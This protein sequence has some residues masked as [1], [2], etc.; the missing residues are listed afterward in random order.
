MNIIVF[1]PNL[2]YGG[3]SNYSIRCVEMLKKEY[4]NV[5][6]VTFY[7]NRMFESDDLYLI[8]GKKLINKIY[9]LR[10]LI[11][12]KGVN[13]VITSIDLAPL[14]TKIAC[15]GIKID[16]ISVFH[17]RP[18]LYKLNSDSKLKNKMFD[19][20][21]V[22]SFMISK[23]VITVSKGLEYEVKK[24]Y[25]K[26][27]NKI[28]TIY[29]PIIK[30]LEERNFHYIDIENKKEINILNIGW[31]SRLKNQ[32]EILEAIKLID[33][34]RFKLTIVGGIK[35]VDYYKKI[36]KFIKENDMKNISFVGEVKDVNKYFKNA[37]LY[38][39]SS[40]SEALPTVLIEALENNVPIIANDC[41]YGPRE[42][43]EGNKYGLIYRDNYLELRDKILYL[44][45]NN[46]Y[47]RFIENSYLRAKDFEY[48]NIIMKYSEVLEN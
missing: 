10:K 38:V 31:V 27:S 35:D 20:L 7:N 24:K 9:N 37:D 33:D 44:I 17:M 47:N 3:V 48:N 18:N 15:L 1:V 23:N 34:N 42:I 8:N 4:K 14:I 26:F 28:V 11:K 21:L 12:N 5:Y 45:N 40:K 32:L 30:N 22:A 16:I 19:Y 6:L 41:K 39:L 29:N 13:K 25:I 46:I 36:L 2:D 43:L